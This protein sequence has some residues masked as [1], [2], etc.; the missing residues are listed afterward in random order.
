MAESRTWKLDASDGTLTLHTG[1]AGRAA[2]M[3]HR[4][5][6]A[7]QTWQIT[8]DWKGDDPVSARLVVDVDSLQVVG[9]EGGMTP[10]SGPEKGVARANGLKTLDVKRFPQVTF[11]AEQI[12]K[13]PDGY[14]MHGPLEIHGTAR[15]ID[16]DLALSADGDTW[17]M[18]A[19]AEVK[20]TDFGIKPYSMA[21]GSMKVADAVRISFA[22]Q[23]TVGG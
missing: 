18:S 5:T 7:M 14:R 2:R 21:L 22:A 8:V 6:I 11:R 9:G 20:Q 23:H 10:L 12:A 15:P 19:E 16:V 3:G 1:V 4:L 13:T 17:R